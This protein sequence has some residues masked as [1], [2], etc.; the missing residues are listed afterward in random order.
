MVYKYLLVQTHSS[1]LFF[2][3]GFIYCVNFFKKKFYGPFL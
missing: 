2:W 3:V 1:D